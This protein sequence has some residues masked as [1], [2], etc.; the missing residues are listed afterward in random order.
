MAVYTAE[1]LFALGFLVS[2]LQSQ[3]LPLSSQQY[4]GVLGSAWGGRSDNAGCGCGTQLAGIDSAAAALA[5]AD[6]GG[7]AVVSSSPTPPHGVSVVSDNEYSGIV[8]VLGQLPFLGTTY[9]EGAVP[10]AG[11]GAV[12]YGCGGGD[13]AILSED[14]AGAAT[15]L[16]YASD[17]I[18]P[19]TFSDTGVCGCGTWF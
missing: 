5:A 6:G 9:L 16:R 19:R 14:F 4:G 7:F 2:S 13:V 17:R 11:A 12:A 18:A 3:C 8:A 15:S 10:S 1:V